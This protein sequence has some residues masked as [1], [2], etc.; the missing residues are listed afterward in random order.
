MGNGY[1]FW[2]RRSTR[3]WFGVVLTFCLLI[4]QWAVAAYVCPPGSGDVARA[5]VSSAPSPCHEHADPKQPGLCHE[6]CNPSVLASV[7]GKAPS[8]PPAIIPPLP[9][10]PL[11]AAQTLDRASLRLIDDSPPTPP[12]PALLCRFLI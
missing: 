12:R 8:V 6:H 10:A 9:P 7:D 4:N 2:R 11:L 1:S 5:L 3:Q